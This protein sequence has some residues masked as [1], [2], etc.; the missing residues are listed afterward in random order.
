M[1]GGKGGWGTLNKTRNRDKRK[2]ASM[3]KLGGKIASA[4]RFG[5]AIKSRYYKRAYVLSSFEIA[6]SETIKR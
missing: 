6:D 5:K 4:A 2:R 1:A 3:W